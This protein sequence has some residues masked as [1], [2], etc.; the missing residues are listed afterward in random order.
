ML[1]EHGVT[2]ESEIKETDAL[3]KKC[4]DIPTTTAA[5]KDPTP[6]EPRLS[7]GPHEKLAP[8]SLKLEVNYSADAGRF[9]A[10]RADV[11]VGDTLVVE[12]PYAAALYPEKFG[13][14]CQTCLARL[15]SVVPCQGR[16]SMLS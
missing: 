5:S 3:L 8:F 15:R 12:D 9:V 16:Y 7:G 2:R 10:A 6:A 4:D 14:N 1:K 13:L 11:A